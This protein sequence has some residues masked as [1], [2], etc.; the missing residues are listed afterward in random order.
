MNV[1]LERSSSGAAHIIERWVTMTFLL[2]KPTGSRWV[3]FC[4]KT[5][6]F[7][8]LILKTQ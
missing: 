7:K 4:S 6:V 2:P 5:I 1:F 3:C 8:N